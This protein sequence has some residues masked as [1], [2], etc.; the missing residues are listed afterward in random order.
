MRNGTYFRFCLSS[1][2]LSFD[3]TRA[4]SD[5]IIR[6]EYFH[7][8]P[9]FISLCPCTTNSQECWVE[10][11]QGTAS[12]SRESRHLAGDIQRLSHFIALDV[13]PKIHLYRVIMLYND[14]V[15][16]KLWTLLYN[17]ETL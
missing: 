14:P 17:S 6:F 4:F 8:K 10:Y 1:L 16:E 5:V 2:F 12:H 11:I 9:A 7:R 3:W 13:P 15:F